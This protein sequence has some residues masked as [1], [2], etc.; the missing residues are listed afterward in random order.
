MNKIDFSHSR[1][2]YGTPI[3]FL[4]VFMT[5]I[6]AAQAVGSVSAEWEAGGIKDGIEGY[7]LLKPDRKYKS[8]RGVMNV[9][10]PSERIVSK[11]IAAEEAAEWMY[12]V[13]RVGVIE[14]QNRGE[15]IY[16]FEWNVPWPFSNREV[17]LNGRGN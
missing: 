3:F 17:I 16:R 10:I 13:K 8:V 6:L 15:P 7:Y 14:Q 12:K 5:G 9:D 2:K 11:I 4:C 1:I